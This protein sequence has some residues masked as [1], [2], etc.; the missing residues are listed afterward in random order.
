MI[1][2]MFAG[3]LQV[4]GMNRDKY[5]IIVVCVYNVYYCKS[6]ITKYIL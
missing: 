4:K 5:F 6:P 3:R 1:Q 2:R